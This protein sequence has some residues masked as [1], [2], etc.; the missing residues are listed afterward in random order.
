MDREMKLDKFIAIRTFLEKS[1]PEFAEF[2]GVSPSNIYMIEK[3]SRRISKQMIGRIAKKFDESSEFI[4]YYQR[5]KKLV[6]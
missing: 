1:Q 6:D 3:G 4:E 5:T 2:L